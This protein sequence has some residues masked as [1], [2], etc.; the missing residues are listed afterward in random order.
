MRIPGTTKTRVE[1]QG[2]QRYFVLSMVDQFWSCSHRRGSAVPSTQTN[3]VGIGKKRRHEGTNLL[4]F[5]SRPTLGPGP[6][7]S[8]V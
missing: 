8:T 4:E 3:I 7:S 2:Q 5:Q 6:R 1:M